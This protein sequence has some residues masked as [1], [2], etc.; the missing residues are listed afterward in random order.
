MK[1]I[2]N[3]DKQ[4]IRIQDKGSI[5]V[6]LDNL[7]YEEKVQHQ[8]NRSSFEKISENPKKIYEKGVNTW[9]EKWYNNKS[10]SKKWKKFITVKDSIPGN[11]YGNVKTHKLGNPTRVITS[12]CNTAIQNLSICDSHEKFKHR[13]EEYKNY[14]IARDYHP[15]LVD[16]Q[17]RKVEMTSRHNARKKNAKRKEVSKAKFIK[18]FNPALPS[19]EG[20][21]RKHI[22]YLHSDEV[23]KKAFPSKKFFVIYK[24]NKNL[25]EMVAPSSYP[26]TS[27]KS[28]NTIVSCNKCDIYKN[29]LIADSKFRCTVTGNTY[30]IIGNLSFDS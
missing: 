21:I 6:I 29:F 10:I 25:K 3:W 27:I 24:R 30:F 12:G 18:T 22:H 17:F 2:R 5:F 14:L 4:T 1:E 20:L 8:R 19:I 11:M 9:I 26:K 28:N 16:K 7:D 23:L 15:G 13:S